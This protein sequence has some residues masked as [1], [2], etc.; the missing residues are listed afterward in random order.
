MKKHL[1]AVLSFTAVLA[2]SCYKDLSTEKTTVI[3]DIRIEVEGVP[4]TLNVLFGD[5]LEIKPTITKA[6]RTDEDFTYL[7]EMDVQA[8]RS[9]DRLELGDEKDL[10][11]QVGNTPS[12]EDYILSLTVKDKIDGMGRIKK[13]HVFVSNSLGE[14]LIVAYTRDGGKTSDIDFASNKA[15][16]YGVKSIKATYVRKIYSLSNDGPLQ[17]RINVLS[18]QAASNGATFNQDNVLVGTDDH[19]WRLDPASYKMRDGDAEM[20]NQYLED[21]YGADYLSHLAYYSDVMIVRGSVY[22]CMSLLENKYSKILYKNPLTDKNISCHPESQG[23]IGFF[24]PATGKFHG[25]N[26]AINQGAI[27]SQVSNPPVDFSTEGCEAIAAG[28]SKNL[29]SSFLI[30]DASGVYHLAQF[31][32][33]QPSVGG[34]YTVESVPDIDKAV[35]FATCD[36]CQLVYYAT[37]DQGYVIVV[38]G[39]KTTTR[40][41]NFTPDNADEKITKIQHYQQGWWG[42]RQIYE[43]DYQFPLE[44]NRLQLLIVTYNEK[45]GEGKIYLRPFNVSTGLL[46][47]TTNGTLSGFGEITAVTATFK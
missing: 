40:K 20:F 27:P 31:D 44:T 39:N 23:R 38:S 7:W 16:T 10:V 34:C 11:Y 8:G 26:G 2:A 33:L 19:F 37:P 3:P 4:D 5:E 30:K 35:T 13:W 18:L 43:G 24:D 46:T 32:L 6:D 29:M 25:A 9:A 28:P 15:I 12:Q 14:G 17:G 42:T 21:S 45:T 36:N 1:L 22:C 41:L 47:M